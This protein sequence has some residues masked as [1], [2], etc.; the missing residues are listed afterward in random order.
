MKDLILD[1]EGMHCASCVARVEGALRKV[2][3]VRAARVNLAT[4]Q[5]AVEL[6]ETAADLAALQAAVS[7]AG[8]SAR[9]AAP[10][11]S[12][13]ESLQERAAHEVSTWRWRLILAGALLAPILILHLA[14]GVPHALAMWGQLALAIVMQ[15]LVGW[16]F[17][18]GAV[19]Q[20]RHL[21][22]NMDTLIALG[23]LAALGAGIGDALS[24]AHT[25]NL[26]DGALILTFITLGKYLEARSKGQASRAILKLLELAPPIARVERNLNVVEVPLAQVAVGET[27]VLR[28]GDK[29]PLDGVVLTGRSELNEAWLTGESLPAPKQSGD[30]VFAGSVNG[31][32]SLRV[33]VTSAS[34][35]TWLAQ[36][37][38]LVR[39]AQESKAGVQRLADWVVAWFVPAVL[40]MA[41]ATLVGWSLAGDW[42]LGLSCAV[43]VLVVA[44]PCA[45]GLATP[46]AVLVGSGRGAELGI[47][48]K[49]AAALETAGRLTAMVLDKTGT[50]TLGKP[51][52][53]DVAA[54]EAV[55]PP[56][57]LSLA[58]A[59]ERHSSHPLAAAVV[60][61]AQESDA[62]VLVAEKT[63]VVP[64]LG[65]RAEVDRRA[66]LVGSR[67]FLERE[68]VSLD[69][70]ARRNA[71]AAAIHVAQEGR[72]LGALML[73]D[74]VSDTSREAIDELKRLGLAV[75]M[76]S[77]DRREVAETIARQV[78]I[79][80]VIAEVKPDQKQAAVAD[81]QGRGQVV[82]MVGDG[83]NDA[84]AL[85]AAD[86][87]IAIGL[88]AD[89]AIES[90]DMVLTRHDLRLVPQAV[91]LARNVLAVI[92][93]NLGWALVYNVLL[94]PLA[95]GVFLP[96]AGVRLHPVLAAAAMAASSVSVVVNSLRL[97]WMK[98]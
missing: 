45:L 30:Q 86:L 14:P 56:R 28:P 68:G 64:G 52:V 78:G 7:A 79:A 83:I 44:C 58:A 94:I 98:V 73:A 34:T 17:M 33:R 18:Q 65:I 88:G 53:V 23:T 84:P 6:D 9:P 57:L 46:A 16:P 50:I 59:V 13:A 81:L 90:A 75:T 91:R 69:G 15:A 93:Q 2:P 24:G 74:E 31:S 10:P 43:A 85:A 71:H 61:K 41:L 37:V 96:L 21:A 87:G 22:A 8:Y 62:P 76:L 70:A 97:R 51:Q 5:G 67:E 36:T 3:G 42:Q 4:N 48:I 72:W 29:V 26:M 77:G 39:R 25:M 92:W 66:V 63:T 55:S 60:R 82:G 40:A 20:L 19:R 27:A 95:A 80:E 11:E 38:E 32:G 89:V 49:E 12:A 1:I 54:A 47:L 35:Q